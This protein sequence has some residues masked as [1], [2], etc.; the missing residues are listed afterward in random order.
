VSK[1]P[2]IQKGIAFLMV[3]LFLFSIAPKRYWHDLLA[4]HTDT[5]AA[6]GTGEASLSPEGF[7]CHADDLVVNTPFLEMAPAVETILPPACTP[8]FLCCPTTIFPIPSKAKDSRGPPAV[9]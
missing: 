9:L 2:V 8:R 3:L 1:K 7:N 5:Y 4:A 6:A